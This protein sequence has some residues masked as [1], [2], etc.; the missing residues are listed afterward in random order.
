MANTIKTVFQFR[1]DTADNWLRNKD[2]VPAMGEPCFVIDKNILKIG[3]GSTRFC[4][5][6]PITGVEVCQTGD[7]QSIVL[8]DNVFKLMGYDVADIGAQPQRTENGIEWIVPVDLSS[9]VK[10]LQSDID[11]VKLESKAL[12]DSI[13]EAFHA[14]EIFEF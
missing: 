13:E 6:T 9:T 14:I 5:L 10:A 3:N 8:E 12:Q 7:G 2:V 1:R 4:D 11:I